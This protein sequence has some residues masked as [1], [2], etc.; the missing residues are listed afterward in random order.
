MDSFM[1]ALG[2]VFPMLV[3]M[4]T[5][6]LLRRRGLMDSRTA[7]QLDTVNFRVF[8]PCLLFIN[9]YRSDLSQDFHPGLVA[10]ALGGFALTLL[11][12]L[13]LVPRF[14]GDRRRISVITQAIVRG[15]FVLFGMSVTEHLYGEGNSGAAALLAAVVVPVLNVTAVL[16]LEAYRP[17]S[18]RRV[19]V[20][21]LGAG[22]AKNPLI[23][24]S[25]LAVL[26]A[27][28][29]LRLPAMAEDAVAS[30]ARAATPLAFVT[31]G[32][33]LSPEGFWRNRVCLL[34]TV[35]A[36][37]ALIPAVCLG[38]AVW[39]G[40]RG[41]ELATLMVYFG[42]P[43]AVSSFTMAQQMGADGELAAQLV[44]LTS[45]AALGTIFVL[46]FLLR[47]LGLL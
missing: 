23:I 12:C 8:L 32:A 18:H 1:V 3:M 36:R 10:F 44:A 26:L 13:L 14:E 21:R 16:L 11:L 25:L 35:L 7:R 31:L 19:S 27:L 24:A 15:N 41:M 2:V 47:S 22:V 40:F 46:S 38:A 39:A 20:R 34:W 33:T 28:T 9:I 5:G 17:G 29:G 37:M 6:M 4:G 43:T 42:A 45:T 30:M